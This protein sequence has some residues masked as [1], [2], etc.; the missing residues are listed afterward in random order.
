MKD[1]K[2]RKPRKHV[3]PACPKENDYLWQILRSV[4]KDFG[5]TELAQE[6]KLNV[7]VRKL[8]NLIRQ[9]DIEGYIEFC[10]VHLSLPAINRTDLTGMNALTV[11]EVRWMRLFTIG[12]KFD[13]C[14]SPFNQLEN[15]L[16]AF[17]KFESL[18]LKTNKDILFD[19]YCCDADSS[20]TID[21]VFVFPVLESARDFIRLVLG[22]NCELQGFL[23]AAHHG[24]GA[25]TLKRG[26][27]SLPVLKNVSPIDVT[28]AARDLLTVCIQEDQRWSRAIWNDY[29]IF[30][31]SA[32]DEGSSLLELG[33]FPAVPIDWAL[34]DAV[35]S[36]IMFVPKNAKTLRTIA[37]EPTGNVYMQL[38]VDTLI[39]KRLKKF[40]VDLSTQEKNQRLAGLGSS[41]DSLAT[42]DLSGASDS[43]A[44]NWLKLFPVKWA[45]LLYALRCDKGVIE[46][47][48]ETVEFQKLSSMGN[49]FTFSVES[50]IFSA[51]IYGVYKVRGS[52]WRDNLPLT[53]VYGDDIIV[54]C[55]FY[56]DLVYIL[57]RTGFC[58][59]EEKSFGHG[60]V[61]ESCGSD[62]FNGQD[63]SRPTLKA[64]PTR[65]WEL[66][67][68]HNLLFMRSYYWDFPLN[69]TLAKIR[70]WI[71][72]RFYG[73]INF[74]SEICWLFS[75]TPTTPDG[76]K[77]PS[78]P[79]ESQKAYDWQVPVFHL[80]TYVLA[81]PPMKKQG[82][83]VRALDSEY[84]A[85]QY[86]NTDGVTPHWWEGK[87][88]KIDEPGK[89]AEKYFNKKLL[90]VRQTTAVIPFYLWCKPPKWVPAA[91]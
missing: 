73:P 63:I 60:P 9:K 65:D 36:R 82:F 38:A 31:C 27:R 10:D 89:S 69:H 88:F 55:E 46:A 50:L 78:G 32:S 17:R 15:A 13:F 91:R 30:G 74:D 16:T 68:D 57:R 2:S 42:I 76:C 21:D 28:P 14:N 81:R 41:K 54:P 90:I 7:I 40:G 45:R 34:K 18:C 24:P 3:Q 67:R 58:L 47:T 62:F 29:K 86:L 80:K 66:V 11:D 59:N 8:D 71:R 48:Q 52:N 53:A 87:G 70:S 44:L 19:V 5:E 43:I 61:R 22:D 1:S 35:E 56:S 75:A 77:T 20:C 23:S 85:L 51:L 79:L 25:T 4:L 12:V 49:G 72:V 39:K 64:T 83:L 6:G 33:V 37:T 84:E 26:D